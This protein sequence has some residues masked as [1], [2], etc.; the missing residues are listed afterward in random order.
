MK[1]VIKRGGKVVASFEG[2]KAVEEAI[3]AIMALSENP[4]EVA[5]ALLVAAAM[6][7]E[8]VK[9]TFSVGPTKITIEEANEAS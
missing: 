6:A 3:K 9:G 1:A 2:E 5:A 7:K 8:N 4:V